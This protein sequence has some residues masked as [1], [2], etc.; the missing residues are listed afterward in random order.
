MYNSGDV[1]TLQME[2]NYT[3]VMLLN[4]LITTRQSLQLEFLSVS[5]LRLPTS[6]QLC[7]WLAGHHGRVVLAFSGTTDTALT[8]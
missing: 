2:C 3:V 4:N 1:I 5:V 6:P 8:L 7:L